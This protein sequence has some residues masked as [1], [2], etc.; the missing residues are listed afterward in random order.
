[1]PWHVMTMKDV[2]SCDKPRLD[3][4]NR[5]TG[6]FRIGQPTWSNVQG[7]PIEYIDW[8]EITRGSET[9]QY[10]QEKK[11]IVISRVAASEKEK[12]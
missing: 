3:A 5:L 10:P 7:P 6:D 2:I 4:N 12:A 8:K 11:T 9:S 1:M